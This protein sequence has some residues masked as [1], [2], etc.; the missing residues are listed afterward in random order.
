MSLLR[1]RRART[2]IA[3]AGAALSAA[4]LLA[5]A[6]G[7]RTT[8]REL[9]FRDIDEELRTLAIAVGSEFEARK[10]RAVFRWQRIENQPEHLLGQ[11]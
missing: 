10:Q 1:P 8:I 2:R 9:T 5:V 7:A 4:L 3:L 6:L 11:V